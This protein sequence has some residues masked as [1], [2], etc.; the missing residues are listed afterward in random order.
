MLRTILAVAIVTLVSA[1]ASAEGPKSKSRTPRGVIWLPETVITKPLMKPQAAIDI[2]RI[3]PRLLLSV[4]P[5]SFVER[6]A[7][8]PN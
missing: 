6:I 5:A 2:H 4:G 1:T 3:P 7:L 8:P